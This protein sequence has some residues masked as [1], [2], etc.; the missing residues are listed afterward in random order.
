[1]IAVAVFQIGSSSRP[2][3]TGGRSAGAA[4]ALVLGTLAERSPVACA[5]MV[6]APTGA[7]TRAAAKISAVFLA[8]HNAPIDSSCNMNP[9]LNAPKSR[10]LLSRELPAG[11]ADHAAG[12]F[13]H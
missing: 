2:S 12:A 1:M 11:S 8:L 5:C 10:R 6:W 9:P 13:T 3:M 4:V 7:V